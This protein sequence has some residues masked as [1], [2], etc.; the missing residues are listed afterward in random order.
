MTTE[1][2]T[3]LREHEDRAYDLHTEHVN[4]VFVKM[5]KTIGFDKHYVRGEGCHLWDAE[6]NKYLDFLTGWG[7]FA[8]GRNHPKVKAILRQVLEEE[9]PNLVRMSCSV[10]S[11]LVA[12]KLTEHVGGGLS[13]VFFCNSGT[14]AV[15]G[16]LKF[17]RCATGRSEIVFTDHAFHGLTTGSLAVNGADFFR[18]RFGELMPGTRKVPFNDLEALERALSTRRAAAFILE[19]VQGKSCEVVHDGYLADAQR[20]CRKYGTLLV[21]DEVQTGLGRTGKWF[22]YQHWPEVEPDI[23]CVSK[24]LSGGFVPVGAIVTR[25]KV[26]DAVFSSL[27][28]CVVHSNTFGQND[29]AMAAA[30]ATLQVIEDDRLVENAE[31][32]GEYLRQGLSMIASTCP[33]VSE[34]RGKGLMFGIDFARPKDSL[35][36]KMAWDMLHGLNFGVFGQMIVI[37][38]MQRHRVLTQVAGYHTEVIKFLPPI[39][40][41]KED[42]DWFLRAMKDVLQETQRFPG[43]AWD[44]VAGLARGTMRA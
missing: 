28:R 39:T 42:C 6:G 1:F 44:T 38:L 35:K 14:E 26:M 20:L 27:E 4:P 3:W 29:M 33:F 23:V 34:V 15:E 13:R 17:A 22:C 9:L 41:G 16:A 36:L 10:L 24:A 19:P 25:P 11:G 18:E 32:Q 8:L 43:A 31:A 12:E 2:V 7:V 40:I 5:L 21:I 37:P 30:L